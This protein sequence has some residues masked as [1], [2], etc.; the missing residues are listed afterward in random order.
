[1]GGEIKEIANFAGNGSQHDMYAASAQLNARLGEGFREP[2]EEIGPLKSPS[3]RRPPSSTP[4]IGESP[5]S[6]RNLGV[7]MPT[8]P[9]STG[10]HP[11]RSNSMGDGQLQ[12]RQPQ[13]LP[14]AQMQWNETHHPFTPRRPRVSR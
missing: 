3:T 12:Q 7:E 1:M 5:I 14:F 13:P 10:F 9:T 2:K 11:L 4:A 6:L 8:V